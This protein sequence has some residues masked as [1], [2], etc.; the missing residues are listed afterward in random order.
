[1]PEVRFPEDSVTVKEFTHPDGS[2][3]AMAA[4]TVTTAEMAAA[5]DLDGDYDGEQIIV[6][7][8][9]NTDGRTDFESYR[10]DGDDIVF[11]MTTAQRDD[12]RE[13]L[14]RML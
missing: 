2:D 11:E 3:A 4:V 8:R 6:P 5:F 1:M 14:D 9:H 12:L 13:K 7:L 10:T